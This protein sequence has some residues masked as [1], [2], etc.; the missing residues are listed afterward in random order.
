MQTIGNLTVSK[1]KEGKHTHYHDNHPNQKTTGTNHYW[2]ITS[3]NINELNLLIKRHKLTDWI[4]KQ[5]PSFCCT[6]EICLNFKDKHYLR[7]KGWK[8]IF[9]SNRPKK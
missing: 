1:L 9:Q 4:R 5:D 3:L 7:V 8:K 6:Q 2:S